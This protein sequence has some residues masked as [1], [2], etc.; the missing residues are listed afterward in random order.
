MMLSNKFHVFTILAAVM[1]CYPLCISAFTRSHAYVGRAVRSTSASAETKFVLSN[2]KVFRLE[3]G[4]NENRKRGTQLFKYKE[5][6]PSDV[7]IESNKRGN[8]VLVLAIF[9]LIW[10]FSIPPEFRRAHFC[11][12]EQCS[13]NRS[14]CYDCVTV[15]EWSEQVADYYRSGGGIHFDFSVDPNP[16]T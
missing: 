11:F 12:T 15:G 3:V 4:L 1:S 6:G 2:G 5:G 7:L 9:A 8:V 16:K 13:Q 14:K 10:S